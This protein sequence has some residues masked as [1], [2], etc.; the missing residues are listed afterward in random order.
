MT[1]AGGHLMMASTLRG[2]GRWEVRAETRKR[3]NSRSRVAWPRDSKWMQPWLCGCCLSA[4]CFVWGDGKD[5]LARGR[6]KLQRGQGE[7]CRAAWAREGAGAL[8]LWPV[9]GVMRQS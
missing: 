5:C 3:W 7:L 4:V 9:A 6:H 8:W 2:D 1:R